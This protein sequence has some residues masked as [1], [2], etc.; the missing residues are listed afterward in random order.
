MDCFSRFEANGNSA[1]CKGMGR[2]SCL[3]RNTFKLPEDLAFFG[4]HAMRPCHA[5]CFQTVLGREL[6]ET[7]L[8]AKQ[9]YVQ[10][11]IHILRQLGS[12]TLNLR[13]F[14]PPCCGNAGLIYLTHAYINIPADD[15]IT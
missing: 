4:R 8:E 9:E 10:K 3:I 15:N 13:Y 5:L 7:F 12:P 1:E 6:V 2:L 11:T 14:A